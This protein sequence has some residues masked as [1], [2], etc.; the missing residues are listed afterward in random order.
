M[1][2][3]EIDALILQIFKALPR[4]MLG[5]FAGSFSEKQQKRVEKM[6]S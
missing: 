6:L 2:N 3:D 4:E 1:S 5:K